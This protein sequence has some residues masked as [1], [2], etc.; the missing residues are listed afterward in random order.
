MSGRLAAPGRVGPEPLTGLPRKSSID[1]VRLRFALLL[2][3]VAASEK[4]GCGAAAPAFDPCAG[5]T[6]GST[7]HPCPP[8]ATGCVEAAVLMA[9]D[10]TG[11]CVAAGT[12]APCFD[13]CAGKTC[14]ASCDPCA[15][16]T[17][18]PMTAVATQCDGSGRCLFV[19]Q[20]TPCSACAG[21]ACGTSCAVDPPCYPLCLAPS[22]LGACDGKG[23]CLAPDQVTCTAA[24]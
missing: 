20:G 9:C 12:G 3:A 22:Y 16:G 13:P 6:C 2:V 15:P 1:G 21:A 24:P 19:G 5:L 4:G 14:G 18:C 10:G 17:P 7:C 23:F 8:G 11:A